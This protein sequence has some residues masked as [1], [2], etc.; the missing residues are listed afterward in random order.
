M[1]PSAFDDPRLTLAG[2]LI[3]AHGG[4][5]AE[6]GAVHAAH[7]LTGTDFDALIRLARSAGQR[8][9]MSDLA[10]QTGLSTSGMTRIIDRL[11]RRGLTRRELSATDRRSWWAILTP[12]GRQVLDADIPPLLT[13]I[14]RCVIDRLTPVQLEAVTE[15]LRALRDAVRPGAH[16]GTEDGSTLRRGEARRPGRQAPAR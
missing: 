8:L 5:T 15:G 11:E 14:Q 16:A 10:A 9:T 6:M 4:L 12:E 1:T 3:E 7:G 13:T 2:L